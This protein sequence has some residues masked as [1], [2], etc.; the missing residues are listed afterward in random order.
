MRREICLL[1][2][3]DERRCP[4]QKLTRPVGLRGCD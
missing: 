1:Q 2:M 4:A 3:N